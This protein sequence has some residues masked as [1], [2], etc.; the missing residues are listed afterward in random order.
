M[1]NKIISFPYSLCRY[2]ADLKLCLKVMAGE[3]ICKLKLDEKVDISKINIFYMEGHNNPFVTPL[4]RDIRDAINR[5]IGVLNKKCAKIDK[6]YLKDL[7]LGIDLWMCAMTDRTAPKFKEE[8]ANLNGEIN[9]YWELLKSMFGQ[10]IYTLPSI[11]SC[12]GESIA[13]LSDQKYFEKMTQ[14][15]QNLTEKLHNILGNSTL[16]N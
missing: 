10:S 6:L 2:A 1:E 13:G 5:V 12:F 7:E 4:H 8:L 11:V 15:R 14:I 3:N 9:A 16:N